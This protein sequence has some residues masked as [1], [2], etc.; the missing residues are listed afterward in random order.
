MSATT[1]RS[2][3]VHPVCAISVQNALVCLA[4]VGTE[5]DIQSPVKVA[6]SASGDLVAARKPSVRSVD[7][8]HVDAAALLATVCPAAV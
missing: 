2:A 5:A 6:K 1:V 8:R 7:T 4:V 3:R